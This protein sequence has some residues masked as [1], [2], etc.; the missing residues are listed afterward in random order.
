ML[1]TIKNYLARQAR[2]PFGW[3]GRLMAPLVFNH[4]NQHIEDFGLELMDPQQDDHILEIGF[5]HG[6][7]ISQML[8]KITEGKLHGIDISEQ[9]VKVTTNR[10]RQWIENGKLV[11]KQASIADIP[12][13][14]GYFNKV[15]TCNT[16][17]FWP[18][19][20]E[21]IR[22]VKRVLKPNGQFFCA[23]R[24]KELME[25]KG[26]A[27]TDNREVFQNL[28]QPDEVIKLFQEGGLQNVRHQ[29]NDSSSEEAHIITGSK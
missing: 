3:F 16:I 18:D 22:E 1:S 12:Y 21:N 20:V 15:F 25:S 11:L 23:F 27:V 5:G 26:S 4:E 2:N 17:Y 29:K 19:P 10:N 9:M 24:D 28:Y 13:P 8:P 7:L 14:E 6:R